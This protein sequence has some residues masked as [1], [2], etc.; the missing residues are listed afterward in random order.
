MIGFMLVMTPSGPDYP[1]LIIF[2][3]IILLEEEYRLF[4]IR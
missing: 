2:C 4:N 1:A 3:V